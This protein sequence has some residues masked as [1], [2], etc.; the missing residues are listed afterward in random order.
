MN[1]AER[2]SSRDVTLS[3]NVARLTATVGTHLSRDLE[4][5]EQLKRDRFFKVHADFL[6]EKCSKREGARRVHPDVR[7]WQVT[8]AICSRYITRLIR[9]LITHRRRTMGMPEGPSLHRKCA[10]AGHR[11]STFACARR[12]VQ[13]STL[14]SYS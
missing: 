13:L 4:E 11:P 12:L 2:L 1:A 6:R 8:L 7:V 3:T 10:D 14:G 9:H 5:E